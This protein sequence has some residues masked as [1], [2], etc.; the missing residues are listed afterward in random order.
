MRRSTGSRFAPWRGSGF[1]A[2]EVAEQHA[3]A[4]SSCSAHFS[5]SLVGSASRADQ[6]PASGGVP[7]P[8]STAAAFAAAAFGIDERAQV[9]E[10]VGGDESRGD[11]F[12]ERVLHFT[13]Q[14]SGGSRQVGEEGRV[15]FERGEHV[16]GGVGERGR[17]P[18]PGPATS[19]S[20][21]S[22]RNREMGAMRVGRI[23]CPSPSVNA[24]MGGDAG[25][26]D[27]AGEAEFVE[28]FGFV[29]GD[30]AGKDLRF[31]GGGGDFVALQL[32]DDLEHA[33]GSV[34]L[35]SR[36]G[37]LPAGEEVMELR[38]VTGSISRRRRPR[39]VR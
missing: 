16:G 14:A 34:Q 22:R 18:V 11:Q 15:L 33:V 38:A 4:A 2:T 36:A 39:V 37:V 17:G 25:P 1:A 24:G 28:Q 29:L 19:Q 21:S 30:S 31:P 6:G 35:R 26:H 3:P 9:F 20:A 12:P 5:T 13:G 7:G 8:G 32:A 23:R 10:A 27:F